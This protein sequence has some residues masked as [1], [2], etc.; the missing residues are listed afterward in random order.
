[1]KITTS[2][3]KSDIE[4]ERL[5]GRTPAQCCMKPSKGPQKAEKWVPQMKMKLKKNERPHSEQMVS[6][7][8]IR[9]VTMLRWGVQKTRL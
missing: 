8:Q 6:S 5:H 2:R 1:M 3:M 4:S 7:I 9:Y